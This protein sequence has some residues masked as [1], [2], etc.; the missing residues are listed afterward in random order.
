MAVVAPC[1]A[2]RTKKLTILHTNDTHS[3]ILPMNPNLADTTV[4]G[5]GGF[6][7]RITMLKEERAKEPN[8]LYI[9]SGD[10]FQGSSYYTMFKGDVEIGLMNLMGLD[11]TTIGNHEWDF[12]VEQLAHNI[13]MA[14]FPV[15]CSNYEFTGTALEGLIKPYIITERN[16]L[17]IGIFALCPKLDGLVFGKNCEGIVYNDPAKCGL[18]IATM[19]KKKKKCDVVICISH[20]GWSESSDIAMIKAS[21]YIDVVLGG[22][23]HSRFDELKYVND[24]D[25]RPVAVDQN[26]KSAIHVGKITLNLEKGK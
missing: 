8:L 23:S 15:V 1:T 7:R 9:D 25:N 4:A 21:R 11:A 12:G 14:N 22:H 18:E 20:L 6:V 10:F 3:C 13:K 17:K 19:L 5:R 2:Q 16:G 24:L 26:G